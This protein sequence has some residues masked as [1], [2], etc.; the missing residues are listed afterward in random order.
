[1]VD[2][3]VQ[4]EAEERSSLPQEVLIP[5]VGICLTLPNLI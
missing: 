5:L 4:T 1:M 2:I 3:D